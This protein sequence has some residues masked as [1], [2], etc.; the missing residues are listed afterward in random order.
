[1]AHLS[2]SSTQSDNTNATAAPTI[3]AVGT[4]NV[5]LGLVALGLHKELWEWAGQPA[6]WDMVAQRVGQDSAPTL[7]QLLNPQ[8]DALKEA[9]SKKVEPDREPWFHRLGMKGL[10]QSLFGTVD[11]CKLLR[12][13][14]ALG[15]AAGFVLLSITVPP[16]TNA[17][18]WVGRAALCYFWLFLCRASDSALSLMIRE[19]RQIQQVHPADVKLD[20]KLALLHCF[21][22][23]VRAL[24]ESWRR[25]PEDVI[26]GDLLMDPEVETPLQ[27]IGIP[28]MLL[29]QNYDDYSWIDRQLDD[30]D[31]QLGT[32]NAPDCAGVHLELSAVPCP[33]AP[34]CDLHLVQEVMKM[35]EGSTPL[36]MALLPML[37]GCCLWLDLMP[38]VCE[39]LPENNAHDRSAESSSSLC[40]KHP[41]DLV[42]AVAHTGGL[43]LFELTMML[44]LP[45][46]DMPLLADLVHVQAER[47]RAAA[48]EE[49][50]E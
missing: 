36:E 20:N 8:K 41:V 1:M 21:S 42:Q 27:T 47:Q 2:S 30:L 9:S 7:Q 46:E 23:M 37:I 49:S 12:T 38:G 45:Y 28:R 22:H 17:I 26:S 34:L 44:A 10:V 35:L 4:H 50:R 3:E 15:Q 43:T 31:G 40:S 39:Q 24:E 14:T 25:H 13:Q 11:I 16:C 32:L 29:E 5:V 33:S 19:V 48:S 18:T 6:A